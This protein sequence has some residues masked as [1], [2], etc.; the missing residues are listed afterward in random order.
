MAVNTEADL[1]VHK[2]EVSKSLSTQL[3]EGK[4]IEQSPVNKAMLDTIVARE[5]TN[6]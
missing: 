5:S 3:T 6:F 2:K 1:V 4:E